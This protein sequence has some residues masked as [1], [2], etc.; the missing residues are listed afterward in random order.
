MQE[1]SS[2]HILRKLRFTLLWSS[3]GQRRF[4]HERA[5]S[6]GTMHATRLSKW[7]DHRL[8][9]S[10]WTSLN[11]SQRSAALAWDTAGSS[12]SSVRATQQNR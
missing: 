8:K 2:A 12:S 11:H 7:A 4:D 5:A 3:Q 6:Q 9:N 1:V 10:F